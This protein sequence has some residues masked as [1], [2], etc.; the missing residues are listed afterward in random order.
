[1]Y[2]E[3]MSSTIILYERTT[4]DNTSGL[5]LRI[6]GSYSDGGKGGVTVERGVRVK[7]RQKNEWVRTEVDKITKESHRPARSLFLC[8][9]TIS[10]ANNAKNTTTAA[11]A[12]AAVVASS[13]DAFLQSC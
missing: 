13:S 3:Y 8:G 5:A 9:Q 11:T 7:T 12:A 2:T 1:M 10:N 6:K 4:A